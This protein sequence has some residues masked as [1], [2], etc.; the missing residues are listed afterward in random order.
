TSVSKTASSTPSSSTVCP[1]QPEAGTYCGFINPEDPCAP[2]PDGYGPRPTPDTVDAFYAYAP[3]HKAALTAITP[4]GYVNTFKDL[5]ASTSANTYLGLYTLTSYDVQACAQHC[6]DTALCTGVNVYIERDPL[7][8]SPYCPDPS[9]I[10]NYK[11]NLWGSGVTK[12]TATN[13]GGWRDQFQV[14]I[15]GSNGY[16]TTNTATP[17]KCPGFKPPQSC[18][19]GAI[20]KF[21]SHLESKSFLG[22]FNPNVYA[23]YGQAQTAVNKAAAAKKEKYLPCNSFN[24]YMMKLNGKPTGTSCSL[25]TGPVDSSPASYF[26]GWSSGNLFQVESSWSY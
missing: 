14:V 12:E 9:S 4:S 24:A 23:A 22:P 21:G 20:N 1:T 10:T 17:P 18:K 16:E 2:Q 19:G 25:Y 26:G 3:F 11:C 6:E 7:K 15:V 13:T 5:N 8:R